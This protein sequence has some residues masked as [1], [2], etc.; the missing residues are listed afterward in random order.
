MQVKSKARVAKH[1]EVFTN[2]RE[3]NAM[4]DLVADQITRIDATF[5]EPAC[6]S[7][8]FLV[9]ILRRRMAV[10]NQKYGKSPTEYPAKAVQAVCGLYGIE[11]LPDNTAEC[12][13]RLFATFTAD[14]LPAMQTADDYPRVRDTVRRVLA[15]NIVC[16]NALT[17]QTENGLPITFIQWQFIDRVRVKA[18][19]FELESVVETVRGG[20]QGDLFGDN[21]EPARIVQHK[22][23]FPPVHYLEIGHEAV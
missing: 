19:R 23:E 18:K 21:G 6:G 22:K 17:Y 14:Y 11:L 20:A 9:E 15:K 1:G 4:L 2:P 8:N 16:G 10:L 3:V 13:A 12:R 5:L 7:G